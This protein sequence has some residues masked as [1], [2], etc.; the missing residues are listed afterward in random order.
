MTTL[1]DSKRICR[2]HPTAGLVRASVTAPGSKSITNRLLIAGLVRGGT[3]CIS[4]ILHSDNTDGIT[5][6][7]TIF[8]FHLIFNGEKLRTL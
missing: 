4:D 8:G 1:T 6:A 2:I 7:L 3:S 5:D